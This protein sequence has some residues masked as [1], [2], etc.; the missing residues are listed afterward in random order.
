MRDRFGEKVYR[1]PIDAGFTCPNR[2]GLVAKGGCTYCDE[3]GSG[4]GSRFGR[5]IS[6]QVKN[7]I[8][9]ISM[10]YKANRF[11]AYFQ[12]FSNT[13]DSIDVLKQRYDQALIDPRIVAMAIATRPDCIDEK[14]A[15][16]LVQYQEENVPIWIELGLQSI[17][18][19]TLKKVNRGHTVEDFIRG[20]S[21]L[22]DR[23]LEVCA[24]VIFGMMNDTTDEMLQ[25]ADLLADLKVKGVKLHQLYFI[26]GT[27]LGNLYE[28][29]FI[30]S[31]DLD[32]YVKIAVDFIEKLPPTTI[33]H[34][35]MGDT[36][37]EKLLSPLWALD[38]GSFLKAILQ[39]FKQRNSYQGKFY[40]ESI[41]L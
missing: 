4:P 35:L 3:I 6:E 16:F 25:M 23:N 14:I 12:A 34:R 31:L 26:K 38:K 33:L 28:K 10:R 11:I 19:E 41:C 18:N 21:L 9:S 39:E 29:G 27:P 13:Y 37:E 20:V 22:H 8:S 30:K 24:H 1:L 5:S 2:D 40:Q 7:A 32:T 36:T 15:D 17:N